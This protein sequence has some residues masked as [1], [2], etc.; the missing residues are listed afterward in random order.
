MRKLLYL[1]VSALCL[2]TLDV[3]A[4]TIVVFGDSLSVGH[5]VPLNKG[6]A[7]ILQQQLQKQKLPYR[8]VN[9]SI[10]GDTTSS[11]VVRLPRAL[12]KHKPVIVVLELGGNDGLRGLSLQQTRQN[13]DKM[14]VLIKQK[15]IKLLLVGI[16]LPP[17]YGPAYTEKFH[18]IYFDLARKHNV[19]LLPFMLDG[20]A[21]YKKLMQED[22]IHPNTRAQPLVFNNIWKYLQKLIQE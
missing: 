11:G 3:Q 1:I 7:F 22:G 16:K 5:G 21:G 19:P 10:G 8:L 14:I 4:K 18:Q 13:L 6:W 12:K 15:K 2:L 20:V 9:A 17:N